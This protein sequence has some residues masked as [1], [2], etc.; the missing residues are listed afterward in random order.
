LGFT[1][2]AK[3]PKVKMLSQIKTD[4][5]VLRRD[6]TTAARATTPVLTPPELCSIGGCRAFRVFNFESVP[7]DEVAGVVVSV[8]GK[9]YVRE[10]SH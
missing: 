4:V 3:D 9:L 2:D 6:G 10:I 8:D 1:P 7:D 5:W